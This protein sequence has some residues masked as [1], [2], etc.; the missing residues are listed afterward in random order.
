ME[1]RSQF[2]LGN[3]EIRINW[4]IAVFVLLAVGGLARLGLW[5][6]DLKADKE[7]AD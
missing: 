1:L 4:F 2:R 3:F 7:D 6:L 5:Q